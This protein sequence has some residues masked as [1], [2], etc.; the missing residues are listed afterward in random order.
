[1]A[2]PNSGTVQLDVGGGWAFDLEITTTAK[3]VSADTSTIVTI[4]V[5]AESS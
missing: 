1:M 5:A 2:Q 3:S 4:T